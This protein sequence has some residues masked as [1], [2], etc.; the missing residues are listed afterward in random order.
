MNNSDRKH[1]RQKLEWEYWPIWLSNLPL[2]FIW[3]WF[4]IRS[5]HLFF[6]TSANPTIETGGLFSESKINILRKIPV[7]YLPITCFFPKG[8]PFHSVLTEIKKNKLSY[9]LIAKPDVGER[10]L[11]VKLI[12]NQE[13][14]E[15]HLN[16]QLIDWIIQEYVDLPTEAS[17]FYHRMPNDNSG[18]ITSLCYKDF[19]AFNGDGQTSIGAW[20]EQDFRASK[21]LNRFLREQ[22]QLLKSIPAA[23]ERIV[24]EP[25]GNHNRGTTFLNGNNWIND[26]MEKAFDV[27][28]LQMPNSYYGRFDLRC[29]SLESLQKGQDFKVLEFNGIGAEPAHIYDPKMPVRKKYAEIFRHWKIIFRIYTQ[30]KARGIR[31]DSWRKMLNYLRK[32]RSYMRSIHLTHKK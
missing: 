10:G 30:Q 3:A 21:Q 25:I 1:W 24:L 11:L 7:Q 22:P 5:R 12:Y 28:A 26:E 8:I 6:F 29:I 18:R 27:L 9:P 23:G 14:L 2:L 19:L 20:M 17:V 15:K 32:Y 4:A 31:P 16:S 13:E